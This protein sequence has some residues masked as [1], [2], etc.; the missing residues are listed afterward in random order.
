MFI[1]TMKQT[2]VHVVIYSNLLLTSTPLFHKM[3]NVTTI[4]TAKTTGITIPIIIPMLTVYNN[5]TVLY[6][7]V[8]PMTLH[9][10]KVRLRDRQTDI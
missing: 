3:I 6:Y 5:K 1:E 2:D 9:T 8:L 7:T 4:A 10:R